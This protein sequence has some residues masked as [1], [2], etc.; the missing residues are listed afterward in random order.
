MNDKTA[1][2]LHNIDEHLAVVR[3]FR[4][5]HGV[6][7]QCARLIIDTF[8]AGGRLYVFGNGGSAADSQHIAAEL[9]GRFKRSDKPALPATALTTDTSNITAIGNDFG[10]DDIFARQVD[11]LVRPGDVVW[12]LS[13]SGRSPNVLKALR[14]AREIGAQ[15]I[16][17]TGRQ[18]AALAD[19][20]TV[21]L[22]ADHDV[23]DRVQ[24]VHQLAYHVICGLIED[25]YCTT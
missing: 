8:Q 24:E 6:V 14:R 25:H 17:F 11:A 19:G 9:V 20:S 2:I 3:S 4:E 10:F 22:V 1:D 15:I 21:V 18:G 5:N 7:A 16:C 12:A 13:V 23:S